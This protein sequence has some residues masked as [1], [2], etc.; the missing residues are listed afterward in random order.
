MEIKFK[1]R[2][3]FTKIIK[4]SKS[5]NEL[6]KQIMSK[7]FFGKY[8]KYRNNIIFY[9]YFAGKFMSKK[10]CH[11]KSFFK[12]NLLYY[13]N[14]ENLKKYYSLGEAI[15]DLSKNTKIYK[16]YIRYYCFPTITDFFFNKIEVERR[17]AHAGLFY[18]IHFKNI[19]HNKGDS[20]KDNGIIIYSRDNNKNESDSKNSIV[21]SFFNEAI[22]KQIDFY[23][24]NKIE[25]S[26]VKNV[27]NSLFVSSSNENPVNQLMNELNKKQNTRNIN[28]KILKSNKNYSN[29]ISDNSKGKINYNIKNISRLNNIYK[30]HNENKGNHREKND[31]YKKDY[32]Y[33]GQKHIIKKDFHKIRNNDFI[34]S[35]KINISKTKYNIKSLFLNKNKSAINFNQ[36]YFQKSLFNTKSSINSIDS[37]SKIETPKKKERIVFSLKNINNKHPK[38][39]HASVYQNKSLIVKLNKIIKINNNIFNINI[40]KNKNDKT[41]ILNPKKNYNYNSIK[42][43]N[44]YKYNN[45]KYISST[46]KVKNKNKNKNNKYVFSR[47]KLISNSSRFFSTG[48]FSV[49][50]KT[51]EHSNY[52][53]SKNKKFPISQINKNYPIR[54]II[55]KP[56]KTKH[57]KS[58]HK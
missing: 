40:I 33:N 5:I 39:E 32:T 23:S 27:E 20:L 1:K 11:I 34:K 10:E 8:K 53:I 46:F 55:I 26:K 15:N 36:S 58:V 3:L 30:N 54:K 9:R 48:K 49:N 51:K 7:R 6:E 21:K 18:D 52:S 41:V 38:N 31:I 12:D 44:Q 29:K 22:R 4:P 57:D 24:P 17:E 14:K 16:D 25:C 43:Q 56:K 47:N 28:I 37:I 19:T 42:H 50:N 2:I 45:E 13:K 35:I